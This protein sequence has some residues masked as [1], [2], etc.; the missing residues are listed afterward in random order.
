MARRRKQAISRHRRHP[1]P[2]WSIIG[3]L[4]MVLL[5]ATTA[6]TDTIQDGGW[7]EERG[8]AQHSLQ[9]TE[10][11]PKSLN[12]ENNQE[13]HQNRVAIIGKSTTNESMASSYT[14]KV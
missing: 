2:V 11:I 12:G 5:L 9:L 3:M 13:T 6:R 14:H 4:H 1:Y 7:S 8:R 10:Q